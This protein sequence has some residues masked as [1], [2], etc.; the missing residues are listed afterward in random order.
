MVWRQ[1]KKPE[2]GTAEREQPRERAN[3][4]EALATARKLRKMFRLFDS[5]ENTISAYYEATRDGR[6]TI[7]DLERRTKE[8]NDEKEEAERELA[9]VQRKHRAFRDTSADEQ[10]VIGARLHRAKTETEAEIGKQEERLRKALD[11]VAEKIESARG[12]HAAEQGK[13]QGEIEALR[14]TRDTLNEEVESL[15]RRLASI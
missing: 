13:L 8:L 7:A 10:K 14:K 6:S 12:K 2:T 3:V 4:E 5:M 11:D 9:E 15:R 1:G